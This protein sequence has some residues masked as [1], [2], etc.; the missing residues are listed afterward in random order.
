MQPLPVGRSGG[1]DAGGPGKAPGAA[2]RDLLAQPGDGGNRGVPGIAQPGD[3]R[4]HAVPAEPPAR[5][6][7]PPGVLRAAGR[8]PRVRRRP[9]RARGPPRRQPAQRHHP[10]GRERRD[11]GAPLC[12]PGKLRVRALLQSAPRRPCQP[13]AGGDHSRPDRSRP[14]ARRH[15]LSPLSP[16]LLRRAAAPRL[17]GLRRPRAP[18]MAVRPRRALHQRDVRE[19]QAAPPTAA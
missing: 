6:R 7:H 19:I 13:R 5:H 12:A 15:F 1:Q 4:L 14:R 17:P 8:R 18:Q 10:P 11:D 16:L 2:R 3:V 9:A